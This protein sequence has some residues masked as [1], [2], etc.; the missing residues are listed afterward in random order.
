MKRLEKSFLECAPDPPASNFDEGSR[1]DLNAKAY[2]AMPAIEKDTSSSVSRPPGREKHRTGVCVSFLSF[3]P[4]RLA[5]CLCGNRE[6]T[7][8]GKVTGR[9]CQQKVFSRLSNRELSAHP[10]SSPFH[11]TRPTPSATRYHQKNVYALAT[12]RTSNDGGCFVCSVWREE[13]LGMGGEHTREEKNIKV[14]HDGSER[15]GVG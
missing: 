1:S 9:E 10:L 12:S 2:I 6:E 7:Q 13:W 14:V 3:H 5:L 4:A 8:L 11:P 15:G